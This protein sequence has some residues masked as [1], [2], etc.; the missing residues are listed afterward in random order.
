VDI[1]RLAHESSRPPAQNTTN[2][3]ALGI[4]A[5][6]SPAVVS[7]IHQDERALELAE[8]S[9]SVEE[10]KIG[11]EKI[12][13]MITERAQK[14]LFGFGIELVDVQLRSIAYK[15]VV[16]QKVYKRMISERNKI[17]MQIRSMGAG[18]KAKILG[19][20]DL[21]LK[22][23]ESEAYR[24]S[25][26]LR[27]H[28]EGEAARIYAAVFQ[29]DPEFFNFIKTLD[30]YKKTM[31]SKTHLLLSTDNALFQIFQKGF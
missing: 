19:Q 9:S 11:R 16:E 23:I 21:A 3:S 1:K 14:E 2:P 13:A 17:A 10:I 27:G 5:V 24:K 31:S 15:E 6:V 8:A 20:L 25:Q 29:E 30:V 4:P 12:A 22:K 7:I 26:E 28:A 18:E